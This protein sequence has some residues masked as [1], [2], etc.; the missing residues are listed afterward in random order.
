M[1]YLSKRSC[2]LLS[3]LFCSFISLDLLAFDAGTGVDGHCAAATFTS[4]GTY[5]CLSV[6]IASAVD[7]A[8]ASVL[9]IKSQGPVT[10]SSN[11]R[12]NGQLGTVGGDAIAGA[13]GDGGTAGA[14]GG[15]GGSCNNVN[16]CLPP[17][18]DG[19]G[20]G[21]GL[22]G[23]RGVLNNDGGGGGAGG[24]YR[25]SGTSGTTGV[26]GTAGGG[27]GGAASATYGDENNFETSFQAGAG[28]GAG[29]MGV[30]AFADRRGAGGGGGGGAIKII[31]AGNISITGTVEAKG[32]AGAVGD[33]SG[34]PGGG[35]GGGSGG[36]IFLQSSGQIILN[37]ANLLLVDGGVGGLGQAGGPNGNGG[38]GGSGRIRLD[39]IDGSVSNAPSF[40]IVKTITLPSSTNNKTFQSEISCG[41]ILPNSKAKSSSSLMF[42]AVFLL[43]IILVKLM[44]ML[45][46]TQ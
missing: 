31:A 16:T 44:Q 27:V 45:L 46:R 41:G 10:I 7:I 5:N 21:K 15:S 38:S 23:A 1:T 40:S 12:V 13:G 22:G 29:G 19:V 32:G 37:A 34:G 42:V 35:G 26:F 3:I 9:V 17:A 8:G 25:T 24:S 43:G 20:D 11:L 14:G 36:A 39:D 4:G 28:G 18:N 30:L 6:T 2:L 33:T